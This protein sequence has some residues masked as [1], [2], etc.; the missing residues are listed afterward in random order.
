MDIIV[1][2]V[3]GVLLFGMGFR[4]GNNPAIYVN[5]SA[6]GL[7]ASATAALSVIGSS[8]AVYGVSFLVP[9]FLFCKLS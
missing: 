6:M 5:L 2:S 4:I 3:L 1:R 7:V 9:G 8:A